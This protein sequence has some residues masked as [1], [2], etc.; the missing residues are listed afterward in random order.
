MWNNFRLQRKQ[1]VLRLQLRIK[2]KLKK[3]NEVVSQVKP[4]YVMKQEYAQ[5]RV[6]L[7][8]SIFDSAIDLQN[9][10]V[11]IQRRPKLLT[12]R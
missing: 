1:Y 11:K 2:N 10:L 3:R 4:Q 12:V 8:S 7:I 6:D 9:E 5:N